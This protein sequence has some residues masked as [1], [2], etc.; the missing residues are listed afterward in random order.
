MFFSSSA[1]FLPINVSINDVLTSISAAVG[2]TSELDDREYVL[3]IRT[4]GI[5]QSTLIWSGSSPTNSFA[6]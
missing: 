2:T 6:K 1:D 4:L 3:D 5:R